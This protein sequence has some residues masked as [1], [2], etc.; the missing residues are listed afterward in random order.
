[1]PI[2]L[3]DTQHL[4]L[5]LPHKGFDTAKESYLRIELIFLKNLMD[6]LGIQRG[7]NGKK[8]IKN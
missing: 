6:G 5:G 2:H 3:S 8:S 1:M 7:R 4:G